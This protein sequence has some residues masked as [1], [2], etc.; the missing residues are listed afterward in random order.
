MSPEQV[1]GRRDLDQRVDVY[2]LGIMLY[3]MLVGRVPFDAKSDY[4]IMKLHAEAPMPLV[5]ASRPDVPPAVDELIQ[6]ACAKDRDQRFQRCEDLVAAVER[7][8]AFAPRPMLGGYPLSPGQSAPGLTPAIPLINATTGAGVP[9]GH[10][11]ISSPGAMPTVTTSQPGDEATRD[12]PPPERRR[13]WPWILLVTVLLAGGAAAG[14][15]AAMGLL[16]GVPGLFKAPRRGPADAGAPAPSAPPDAGSSKPAMA[17]LA[18]AWVGNG[19]ELDAV[20]SGG[21]MEFRVKKPAQFTQ[22]GYE[23][24]EARFVLHPTQEPTVFAVEDR[25][26]PVV[27]TGRA[28]DPRARGT[29]QEVW[30]SVGGTPLRARYDG[31]RLSVE[32]AKIEPALGNFTMEAG[33]VTSCVGLRDL[34]ASK[35]VMVLTRL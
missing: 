20:L 18:G 17:A 2:A 25:I 28:Y 35:V 33:K 6:R 9:P 11:G 32:F 16:P 27:P 3:Q 14:G 31:A 12:N 10:E 1:T 15:V 7:L 26:R 19:R 5:A 23:A 30:T 22:Q 24:G 4:E 34:K 13:R 21:D 29:C 8:L